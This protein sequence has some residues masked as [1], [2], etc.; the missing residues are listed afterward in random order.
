VPSWA[1]WCFGAT[2]LEYFFGE[3]NIQNNSGRKVSILGGFIVGHYKEKGLCEHLC[4]SEWLP[5]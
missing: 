3:E 5:R 2:I 1:A 4:T